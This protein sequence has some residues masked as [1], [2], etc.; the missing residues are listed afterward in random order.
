M[1]AAPPSQ[2][3][4]PRADRPKKG[5]LSHHEIMRLVAEAPG[6]ASDRSPCRPR[7]PTGAILSSH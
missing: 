7:K 1:T 6:P 2:R 4:S 5:L 3:R